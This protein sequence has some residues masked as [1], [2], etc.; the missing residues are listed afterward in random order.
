MGKLN[1]LK[2]MTFGKLQV[3]ERVGSNKSKQ[4]LWLCECQC[5]NKTKLI[6]I[7]SDLIRGHTKSCG[8]LQKEIARNTQTKHGQSFTSLYNIWSNM[9]QRINNK[10]L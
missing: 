7:G 3:I 6:V 2:S 9:K 5:K 8:C 4:A 10:K 1:N